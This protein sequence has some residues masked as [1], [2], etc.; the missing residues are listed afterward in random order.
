L[1]APQGP[2][3]AVL[4]QKI[5]F[6][7][8]ESVYAPEKLLNWQHIDHRFGELSIS[9]AHLVKLLQE[10]GACMEGKSNEAVRMYW[11]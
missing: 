7:H 4:S 6:D 10:R 3:P 11:V 9:D 1:T 2:S 8:K 5:C